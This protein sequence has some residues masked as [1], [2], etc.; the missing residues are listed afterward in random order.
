MNALK[1]YVKKLEVVKRPKCLFGSFALECGLI[2]VFS[3]EFFRWMIFSVGSIFILR[4]DVN[5]ATVI[6][7]AQLFVYLPRLFAFC[8][9]CYYHKASAPSRWTTFEIWV[10]TT[11]LSLLAYISG[12]IRLEKSSYYTI[13]LTLVYAFSVVANFLIDFYFCIVHASF[14]NERII[15]EKYTAKMNRKRDVDAQDG[16]FVHRV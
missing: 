16:V 1:D 13:H 3:I 2:W 12:G 14:A 7:F 4:A 15:E 6:V 8:T 10:L 5:F 9:M 11:V